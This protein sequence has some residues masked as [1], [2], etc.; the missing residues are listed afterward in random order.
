[1]VIIDW[2]KVRK[3]GRHMGEERHEGVGVGM[4]GGR[5]FNQEISLQLY[6]KNLKKKKN[7]KIFLF[8]RIFSS[9]L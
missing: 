6:D 9:P 4:G 7:L 8:S 5:L 1:M 3:S 2:Y